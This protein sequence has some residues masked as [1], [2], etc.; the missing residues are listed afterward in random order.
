MTFKDYIKLKETGTSTASIAVFAQPVGLM[1]RRTWGILSNP[2]DQE[3]EVMTWNDDKKSKKK[4]KKK[5]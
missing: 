1:I 5:K 2:F 4:K 3:P